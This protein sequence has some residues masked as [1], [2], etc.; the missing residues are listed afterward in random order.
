[1]TPPVHSIF[2][3]K[4][5]LAV[6]N[7]L[8]ERRI[9][10]FNYSIPS[11]KKNTNKISFFDKISKPLYGFLIT[12]P[13]LLIL[14]MVATYPVLYVL[15]LSM[16]KF[17]ITMQTNFVGLKNFVNIFTNINFY[18]YTRNSLIYTFGAVSISFT[19]GMI[20][21]LTL[22]KNLKFSG[23]FRSIALWPWAI[24][25]VVASVTW[26]WMYNDVVGVLN[27]LLLRCGLI[28]QPLPWLSNGSLALLSLIIVHAWIDVPFVIV[29]L[30]AGLKGI[31]SELYEAA[32]IDGA[33]YWKQFI[34]ITLPLL[35]PTMMVT[36]LISTTFAFRTFDIV[37]TLTRGG[38]GDATELLVTH[39]YNN[40]FQ[41]L[42][43]GYSSALS[44]IMVIMT[45]LIVLFYTKVFKTN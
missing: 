7:K 40:A 38:P 18:R 26:K 17:D 30:L 4:N 42:R 45:I 10:I 41:F 21:A 31:P 13:S 28:S 43:F 20:I 24:P 27:D 37:F 12:S 25:P 8:Q 19:A 39:V 11:D 5:I 3:I 6:V 14:L 15:F 35:K 44:V 9:I 22:N 32:S 16:T 1:L 23:F 33:S 36:L 2:G 29:L 34:K